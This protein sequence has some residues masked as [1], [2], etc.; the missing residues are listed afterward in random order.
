MSPLKA[1]LNGALNSALI[2]NR[3]SAG[4]RDVALRACARL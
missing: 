3:S 1:R 4:Q 2:M